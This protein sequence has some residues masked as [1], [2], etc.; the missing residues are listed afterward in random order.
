M[1]K[2]VSAS[3][4]SVESLYGAG[5]PLLCPAVSTG[6][7]SQICNALAQAIIIIQSQ[8]HPSNDVKAL[9]EAMVVLS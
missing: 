3:E 7:I 6:I 1:H 4:A 5:C 9:E 2:L 8:Y